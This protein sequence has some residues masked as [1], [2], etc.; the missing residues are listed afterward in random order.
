MVQEFI[1]Y[2]NENSGALTVLVT[3]VYVVATIFIC[4]ANI[5]AAQ[6]SQKQLAEMKKQYAQENRPNIEVEFLFENRAFFGL[7]FINHGRYTAQ[8]VTINLDENFINSLEEAPFQQ[9]LNQL[10]G[11]T[12]IIGVGQHYDIFFGTEKYR[13]NPNK[14]PA[15]GCIRYEGNGLT[16]END[17]EINLE[18]YATIF[19]VTTEQEQLRNKLEKQCSALKG[20]QKELHE[21]NTQMKKNNS[22]MMGEEEG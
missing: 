18:S 13:S 4:G 3:F 22:P 10:Q 11:K 19:S 12:C 8:K 7:R 17:F 5:L 16:Y 1:A 21:L 2:L 14:L 9:Q 15:K 20:I 6:A